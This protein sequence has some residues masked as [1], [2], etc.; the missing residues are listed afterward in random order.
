MFN[1]I[2]T[3]ILIVIV[4]ILTI[5]TVY[6]YLTNKSIKNEINALK[7]SNIILETTISNQN[8]K[9]TDYIDLIDKNIKIIQEYDLKNKEIENKINN[10]NLKLE[11]H[12]LNKIAKN[13]PKLLEK[14]IN[15][16]IEKEKK[17]LMEL[18]KWLK[19]Y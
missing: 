13:K 15:N 6:F 18:T 2:I 12:N 3:K 16:G 9:I 8:K 10:L 5:F 7:Q 11:K 17:E 4:I 19:I 1:N 14:I